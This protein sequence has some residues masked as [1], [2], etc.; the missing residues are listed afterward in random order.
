MPA[1]TATRWSSPRP[2]PSIR[3]CCATAACVT[4]MPTGNRSSPPRQAVSSM[5]QARWA[6]TAPVRS[7]PSPP[8][9]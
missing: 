9:R 1:M 3:P 5:P 7:R 8:R 6:R 4:T 2:L